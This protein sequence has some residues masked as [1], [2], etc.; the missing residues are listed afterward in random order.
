MV[1]SILFIRDFHKS[2]GMEKFEKNCYY[3]II[4]KYNLILKKEYN[5]FEIFN[6][7]KFITFLNLYCLNFLLFNSHF[8]LNICEIFESIELH[9]C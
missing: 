4:K 6:I 5:I 7:V 3:Y 2:N 8:F 1:I 9:L